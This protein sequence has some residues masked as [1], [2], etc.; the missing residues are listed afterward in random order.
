MN[1]ADYGGAVLAD[2][3]EILLRNNTFSANTATHVGGLYALTCLYP[4]ETLQHHHRWQ[5]PSMYG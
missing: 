4:R 5:R 1:S 3:A 2:G